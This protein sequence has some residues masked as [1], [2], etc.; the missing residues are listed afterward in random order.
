LASSVSIARA[1]SEIFMAGLTIFALQV[2][3]PGHRGPATSP[4]PAGPD[5]GGAGCRRRNVTR[6][7]RR[8]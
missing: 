8:A 4:S 2:A 7:I 6:R 5:P 1:V 3:V